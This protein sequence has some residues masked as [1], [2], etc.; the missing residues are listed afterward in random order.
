MNAET[1]IRVISF[2]GNKQEWIPWKAKF[3]ARSNKKKYRFMF[4]FEAQED[5]QMELTEVNKVLQ[6]PLPVISREERAKKKAEREAEEETVK[7]NIKGNDDAYDDLL[8]SMDTSTSRSRVAFNIVRRAKYDSER[9]NAW[10]AWKR[11]NDKYEPKTTPNRARL[12]KQFYSARCAPKQDPETYMS[13]MDDLRAILE[14]AGG[15]TINNEQLM[16]QI[17]N[18]LPS[19]YENVV[20]RLEDFI[21]HEDPLKT[22]TVEHLTEQL[23]LKFSRTRDRTFQENESERDI[24][25][26]TYGQGFKGKCYHCGKYGHK[27]ADCLD[28]SPGNKKREQNNSFRW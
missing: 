12:Q 18:T 26:Q 20:E 23:A 19:V 10:L 15:G 7:K 22:L 14:D 4:Q 21:G 27:G 5:I 28:K 3:L 25:L 11:L 8:L 2:N 1:S 13:Y 24:A 6:T 9:G 16:T 17:L